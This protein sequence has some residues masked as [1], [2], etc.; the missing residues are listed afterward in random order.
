MARMRSL[1]EPYI[2]SKAPDRI[3][4]VV[5]ST[6]G[7]TIAWTAVMAVGF[8]GPAYERSAGQ[9]TPPER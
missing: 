4:A 6:T 5:M 8:T 3:A 2:A 1:T 7:A 9:N